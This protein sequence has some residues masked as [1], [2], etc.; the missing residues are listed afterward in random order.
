MSTLIVLGFET[1]DGAEKMQAE[2]GRLQK[3]KLIELEDAAIIVRDPKKGKPKLK[4]AVDLVEAGA[5]SGA[6]WGTLIGA[7]FL[8]PLF[9]L[10]IGAATGA[11]SGTLS[12]YGINDEFI[13]SFKE[14]V[15]PGHSA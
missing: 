7:I 13:Q 14:Q 3:Q 6:F 9:G 15:K 11:L 8:M 12:D 2:I 1:E 5:W 10:A 4:Q